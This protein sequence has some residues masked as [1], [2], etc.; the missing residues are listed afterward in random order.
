V[1]RV[2]D[3]Q[4]RNNSWLFLHDKAPAYLAV[5]CDAV[6]CFQ[7]NLYDPASVLLARFGTG[8]IFSLRERE[9]GR[10]KRGHFSDISDIKLGVTELLQGI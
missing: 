3:E 1:Y 8:R 4:S 5:E 10:K 9:T 6:Y 7:I 2:R